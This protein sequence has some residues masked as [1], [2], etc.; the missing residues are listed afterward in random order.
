MLRN[1][2][3]NIDVGVTKATYFEMCEMLN[4]PAKDE[5]IPVEFDD[6]QYEVQEALIVYGLVRDEYDSFSGTYLGKQI[7]QILAIM[8]I[9]N[10][11]QN[12]R[13]YILDIINIVDSERIAY[14]NNKKAKQPSKQ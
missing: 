10:I 13:K 8:D 4:E 1:Y 2:L 11:E 5:D 12:S 7:S 9:L 14:Q 6:F 3:Q